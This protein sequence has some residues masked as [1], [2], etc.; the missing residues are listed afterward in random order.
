MRAKLSIHLQL[1]HSQSNK[2]NEVI[3]F[4]LCLFNFIHSLHQ[5]CTIFI[6]NPRGHVVTGKNAIRNPLRLGIVVM[7]TLGTLNTNRQMRNAR[8][9]QSVQHTPNFTLNP[10][11]GGKGTGE[12]IVLLIHLHI[13][14]RIM[15]ILG[16][17]HATMDDANRR[18]D[19][20]FHTHDYMELNRIAIK[21]FWVNLLEDSLYHS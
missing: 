9:T 1:E 6:L 15:A 16:A 21:T 11:D 12:Q 5:A 19:D 10:H 3:T 17:Q 14:I 7:H 20:D 2:Q 13:N 4:I 18:G 8:W